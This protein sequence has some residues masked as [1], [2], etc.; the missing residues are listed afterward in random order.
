MCTRYF[1]LRETTA[2]FA[3][4]AIVLTITA[5]AT[6]AEPI[7]SI[8]SETHGGKLFSAFTIKA[9]Q[10]SEKYPKFPT[11]KWSSKNCKAYALSR[12]RARIEL[13]GKVPVWTLLNQGPSPV[14][15]RVSNGDVMPPLM[16]SNDP[17]IFLGDTRYRYT[18]GLPT[19]SGKAKVYVCY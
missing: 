15:I 12:K 2:A 8:V 18:L 19:S 16:P 4:L 9:I 5:G 3:A 7:H 14:V 1:K 11:R 10:T 13:R 17:T 6:F